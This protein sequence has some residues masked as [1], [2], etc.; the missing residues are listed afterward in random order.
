[1]SVLL[2]VCNA[3]AYLSKRLSTLLEVLPEIAARF[4]IAILEHGSSDAT[5]ELGHDLAAGYP[6]ICVL[7]HPRQMDSS[8][9]L[10]RGLQATHG[11]LVLFVMDAAVDPHDF[12]RLAKAAEA[13]DAVAG[14]QQPTSVEGPNRPAR[15]ASQMPALLLF[16]RRVA[17]AW[18][19]ATTSE[20]L[21]N[22]LMR[23]RY[24]I[25]EVPVR[26]AIEAPSEP[27][28]RPAVSPPAMSPPA[29][30]ALRSSRRTGASA[31]FRIP[32]GPASGR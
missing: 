22:Y 5:A 13:A 10:R 3:Q 6:Q 24:R 30:H 2:P 12:H 14:R 32:F 19:S 17:T 7:S 21:I 29:M 4:E 8:A 9:A 25:V 23:K 28:K 16:H 20:T 1:L 18:R 15:D 26:Q 11:E 27:A 31:S